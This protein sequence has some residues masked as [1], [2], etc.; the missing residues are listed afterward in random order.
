[1]TESALEAAAFYRN[2]ATHR[3]LWTLRDAGGFPAPRTAS[4]Q[5]AQPFWSTR[6]LAE[7]FMQTVPAYRGL[8]VVEV[9]WE[10]FRERWIPGFA[11]AGVSI[12]ADWTGPALT[13]AD[14]EGAWVCECVEME[15]ARMSR[16]RTSAANS[17][18]GQRARATRPAAKE[19]PVWLRRILGRS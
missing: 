6:T 15:I 13:G 16:T 2:V 11:T 10:E 12:G 3:R 9:T 19:Q 17:T 1:M 5:R 18:T 8:E 14:Y 7:W 4:G